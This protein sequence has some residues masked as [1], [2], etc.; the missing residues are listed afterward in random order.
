MDISQMLNEIEAICKYGAILILN[1]HLAPPDITA[2]DNL[3]ELRKSTPIHVHIHLSDEVKEEILRTNKLAIFKLCIDSV[4]PSFIV[5]HQ[6][7][8]GAIKTAWQILKLAQ[9]GEV[10][11]S[12]KLA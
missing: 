2:A 11:D 3:E 12:S 5:C 8:D 4:S 10:G 6:S 1:N 9:S 7:M